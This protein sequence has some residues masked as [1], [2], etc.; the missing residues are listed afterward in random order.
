MRLTRKIIGKFYLPLRRF[1]PF[2][3]FEYKIGVNKYIITI[4]F[5]LYLKKITFQMNRFILT[6]FLFF[7]NLTFAQ[8]C[9]TF[10]AR[11]IDCLNKWVILPQQNNLP[12]TYGYVFLDKDFNLIFQKEGIFDIEFDCDFHP[13][14]S[15][16]VVK[17]KIQRSNI[18]VAAVP[19]DKFAELHISAMPKKVK[20]AKENAETYFYMGYLY[21]EWGDNKKAIVALMQAKELNPKFAGLDR[22]MAFS[23]NSLGIYDKAIE[24]LQPLREK[25]KKDAY[26]YRELIFALAKSGK[27]KE[28]VYNL[29]YSLSVCKDKK[30]H[31]EN[32]LNVLH[33]AFIENDQKI[34]S[35]WI[36]KT[37]T[38][39]KGNKKALDLIKEMEINMKNKSVPKV[40]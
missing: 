32:C 2:S 37:R 13:T 38:L 11:F 8:Q 19:E 35:Q 9:F 10:D 22:E 31:G 21:N 12:Y 26:V 20:K 39:N 27:L 6:L 23:Y 7:T 33:E 16:K 28:A 30:Y 17:T 1:S 4:T 15:K 34:F 14:K 29:K 18:L 24:I 5:M 40:N 36:R 3:I 25:R